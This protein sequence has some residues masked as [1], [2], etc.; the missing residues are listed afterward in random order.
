MGQREL[1]LGLFGAAEL[2]AGEV[3]VNGTAVDLRS[4]ADAVRA[5]IGISL[6]PEDRKTEGLFLDLDGQENVSL[7]SLGRFVRA[8]L[9]DRSRE[10]REVLEAL[11]RVQVP[12]RAL[13]QPVK[14][15]SGGN[16]QK[17]VLAKWLLTGSRILLLYDPTRGVDVGTKA[18][19]YHLI[20]NFAASG[21]A[22]LF[23][24]TEIAELVNLCDSVLV[25]YR[26]RV[27]DILTGKD[28]SDTRIMRA[29]LGQARATERL[30]EA[31]GR[32]LH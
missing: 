23:Y 11:I 27:A 30:E 19:I 26:G 12:P 22:V 21:G 9:V 16:Q 6:V 5:E 28:V 3:A 20:H 15:F 29:A 18:E 25:L 8:G 13:R 31:H 1:F 32:H 4:P 7:P 24:S 14:Q 17:I 10:A 2:T